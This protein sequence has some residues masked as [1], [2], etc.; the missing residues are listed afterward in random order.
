MIIANFFVQ[1][2]C[3]D[4]WYLEVEKPPA[5][6]RV[7]LVRASTNS[8]E[9]SWTAV[10]NAEG[11][12]VQIQKY[13]APVAKEQLTGP[14]ASATPMPVPGVPAAAAAAKPTAAAIPAVKPPA[15]PVPSNLQISNF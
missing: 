14:P 12:L 5:P 7:Q 8:L 6:G 4:L 10:P 9:V 11:Y 13:D 1:V 2:C 3:K 15:S